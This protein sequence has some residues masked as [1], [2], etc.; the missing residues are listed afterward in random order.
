MPDLPPLVS[1]AAASSI[2]GLTFKALVPALAPLGAVYRVTGDTDKPGPADDKFS[3]PG[4]S[5]IYLDRDAVA[6]K[7]HDD[8]LFA[9]LA[10]ARLALD[11][12]NARLPSLPP[13]VVA[14]PNASMS[15]V[16][17]DALVDLLAL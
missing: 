1:I 6:A 16:T 4:W 8:G 13:P 3:F 17:L 14:T 9:T 10:D 7:A 15:R 11:V 2:T 12:E 5:S